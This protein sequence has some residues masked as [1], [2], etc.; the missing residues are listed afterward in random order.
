MKVRSPGSRQ[1]L[2][3]S[4]KPEQ[5]DAAGR[6]PDCPRAV[7]TRWAGSESSRM[8]TGVALPDA[9]RTANQQ[10]P[11]V[12]DPALRSQDLSAR[13]ATIVDAISAIEV[14]G[15]ATEPA[16]TPAQLAAPQQLS[17]NRFMPRSPAHRPW[18]FVPSF[19]K[20]IAELVVFNPGTGSPRVE[21]FPSICSTIVADSPVATDPIYDS[22]AGPC[23]QV[24]WM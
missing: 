9:A 15:P 14:Q 21:D 19:H 20:D 8:S 12:K 7:S 16:V 22:N 11:C 18:H 23:D 1:H 5:H 10:G 24:P 2:S 3:Y 13:G 4:V 6:W 17:E